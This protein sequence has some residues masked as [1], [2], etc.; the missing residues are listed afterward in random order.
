[1]RLVADACYGGGVVQLGAG[2][3]PSSRP[4]KEGISYEAHRVVDDPSRDDG[5]CHGPL[6]GGPG[7]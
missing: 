4:L 3:G 5:C 2:A 7:P 6:W 1:M